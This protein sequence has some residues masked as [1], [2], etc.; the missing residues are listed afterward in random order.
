MIIMDKGIIMI[1]GTDDVKNCHWVRAIKDEIRAK[2]ADYG[3]YNE[4]DDEFTHEI[5]RR[6][7]H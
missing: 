1:M 3:V 7:F 2:S 4:S 6:A 5:V